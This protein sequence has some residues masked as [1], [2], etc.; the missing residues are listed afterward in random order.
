QWEQVAVEPAKLLG[1]S[2]PP[3]G[4][5][6]VV[7]RAPEEAITRE[8][9]T[10]ELL[11]NFTNLGVTAKLAG[12]SG[13]VWVTRL[14]DGQ[15]QPGAEVAIRDA[16]GRVRWRGTTGPDGAVVTPGH[17]QLMPRK[18]APAAAE[19]GGEGGEEDVEADFAGRPATD[20]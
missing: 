7:L 13:L 4:F 15:P 20:L 16:E 17:A 11:L 19:F 3:N 1:S 14:S 6:Y 18:R 9:R 12:P 2:A 5:Y 10:R 8:V